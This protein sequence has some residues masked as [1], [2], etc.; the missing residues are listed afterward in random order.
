MGRLEALQAQYGEYLAADPQNPNLMYLL[1]RVL[2]D[3]PKAFELLR[4]ATQA[5]PPCG[6]AYYS[7]CGYELANPQFDAA[8][9]DG[10]HAMELLP[11]SAE[12]PIYCTD[13]SCGGGHRSAEV[14]S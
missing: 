6:W 8:A 7:L 4:N 10:I 11:D 3:S 12:I 14:I 13:R 9:V 5:S 1:S 2:D